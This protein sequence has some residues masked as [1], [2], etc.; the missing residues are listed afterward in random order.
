MISS[1]EKISKNYLNYFTSKHE[2]QKGFPHFGHNKIFS[3]EPLQIWQVIKSFFNSSN[4]PKTSELIIKFILF[5]FIFHLNSL[6]HEIKKTEKDKC[7]I[8]PIILNNK[9]SQK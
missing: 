1:V 6:V 3:V 5:Y 7:I 4:I 9:N 8:K 2:S